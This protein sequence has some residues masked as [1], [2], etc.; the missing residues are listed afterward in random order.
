MKIL[1]SVILTLVIALAGCDSSVADEPSLSPEPA[2]LTWIEYRYDNMGRKRSE[3]AFPEDGSLAVDT[4]FEASRLLRGDIIYFKPPE[5]SVADNPNFRLPSAMISRIV[6]LPG[7]TIGIS[8]GTISVNG[9]NVVH[10]YGRV[11]KYG[12]TEEDYVAFMKEK[13][14]GYVM[15]DLDRQLFGTDMKKIRI[16]DDNYFVINDNWW[17]SV[18]SRSFGPVPANRIIGKVVGVSRDYDRDGIQ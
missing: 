17:R 13:D 4:N 16:P 10:F 8:D 7:D 2:V 3:Y 18:D 6:A 14:P 11:N 9:S 5:F 12:F 15:S 1:K